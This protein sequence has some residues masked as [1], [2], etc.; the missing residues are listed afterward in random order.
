MVKQ[1]DLDVYKAHLEQLLR[2]NSE[3]MFRNDGRE[4][5]SV[6]M[7]V[8]LASTKGEMRI[9]CTGFKPDLITTQPYWN[10]LRNFLNEG[11]K[12][13]VLCETDEA[14]D[15]LPMHLL[16]MEKAK[17]TDKG[18]IIVKLITKEDRRKICESVAEEHCNFSISD[19]N[20]YRFEYDPEGYK[21]IGSFNRPDTC[22]FLTDLFDTSFN[23][24][25][26][27]IV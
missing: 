16:R 3:E 22:K 9:Y 27:V 5:A 2:S 12:I 13:K 19:D 11:K 8:M 23:N 17:R 1:I 15:E 14:K 21:A 7:S 6:L 25:N 26:T 20:K 10:A 24:S 18:S 4:Y